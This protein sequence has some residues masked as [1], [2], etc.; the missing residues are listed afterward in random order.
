MF[1]SRLTFIPLGNTNVG[2]KFVCILVYATGSIICAPLNQM[3]EI[4]MFFF[5]SSR[6]KMFAKIMVCTCCLG[7]IK[8]W[9]I[10]CLLMI[11]IVALQHSTVQNH[12]V[13]AFA[14]TK[15]HPEFYPSKIKKWLTQN[16][17]EFVG[18]LS[19]ILFL[20]F[21]GLMSRHESHGQLKIHH[22]SLL[23]LS[24]EAPFS[25][26]GYK[27]NRAVNGPSFSGPCPFR[28]IK[29]VRRWWKKKLCIEA[30]R[31]Y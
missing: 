13:G 11:R 20:S 12:S 17:T 2:L 7:A 16:G 21:P 15:N 14:E 6:K 18:G 30:E 10:Y 28:L 9:W 29:S 27:L 1:Y 19:L 8:R 3:D 24:T 25:W 31:N 22:H 5:N 23:L 26:C 4:K